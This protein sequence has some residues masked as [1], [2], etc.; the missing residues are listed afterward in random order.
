MCGEGG[1]SNLPNLTPFDFHLLYTCTTD[2]HLHMC[3]IKPPMSEVHCAYTV[4][5]CASLC[6]CSYEVE[7]GRLSVL[8][9]CNSIFT[10]IPSVSLSMAFAVH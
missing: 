2:R 7:S 10:K 6:T 3:L 4:V 8:E 1:R 5:A 9:M